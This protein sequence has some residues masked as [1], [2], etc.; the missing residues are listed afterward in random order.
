MNTPFFEVKTPFLD[1]SKSKAELENPLFARADA[2]TDMIFLRLT[3]GLALEFALDVFE[4]GFEQVDCSASF[5]KVAATGLI[6]VV[7]S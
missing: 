3:Q 6:L 4:C 1:F 2:M 5:Y 7:I